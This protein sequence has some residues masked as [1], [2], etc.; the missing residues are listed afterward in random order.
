MLFTSFRHSAPPDNQK[1]LLPF[2][3]QSHGQREAAVRRGG[4]WGPSSSTSNPSSGGEEPAQSRGERPLAGQTRSQLLG[5]RARAKRSYP[6]GR[7]SLCD[8]AR[9]LGPGT[10]RLTCRS[11]RCDWDTTQQQSKARH[12]HNVPPTASET[13]QTGD[14]GRG[15]LPASTA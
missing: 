11:P 1:R 2:R 6:A 15:V 7:P 3:T 4:L 14:E 12:W 8:P 10:G 9:D 5:P 13:A